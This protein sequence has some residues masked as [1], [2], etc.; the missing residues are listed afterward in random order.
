MAAISFESSP[1]FDS[2]S[3]V[4]HGF[5]G[6]RGGV[7]EDIYHSLNCS[8]FSGDAPNHV[9]TNR[10]LVRESLGGEV[11][12]TVK[13]VHGNDL[14]FVEESTSTDMIVEAD[15]LLTQC[16]G[17][18]IGVMSADCAP[19]VFADPVSRT[20]AVA[21]AGWGGALKGVT[22]TV[23]DRM[24]QLG[25][26]SE[27]IF[28]AIGPCIQLQSYEVG[29][30]FQQRFLETSPIPCEDCFHPLGPGQSI[31]FDLPAYLIKRLAARS[32]SQVHNLARDTY[33]NKED[34]FSFRLN[35]HQNQKDYGRQISAIVIS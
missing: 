9:E 34:Y 17:K 26:R 5:F 4:R 35:T 8:P 19:V 30:E 21:H 31:H 22:D 3:F 29:I 23:V 11:L 16:P 33:S 7:S 20:V 28:C 27:D 14:R 15:A 12:L 6:R 1:L 10:D 32:V 18:V 24:Q 2:T 13:Q 25:A